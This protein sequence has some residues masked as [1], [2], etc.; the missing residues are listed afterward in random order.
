TESGVVVDVAFLTRG[1]HGLDA[2][3]DLPLEGSRQ[4]AE[5]RSREASAACEV[6]GV[7]NVIFLN[8]SDT[9]LSEEPQLAAS[10]ADVLRSGGYQ[11]VFCPWP[12]DSH[13]DHRATFAHL[14]RAV[15]ESDL[16]PA[17]WLY[18]VWKPLPANTY[19]PIDGTIETKR[20][21]IEQYQSQLPQLNYREGFLGLA[22]Y[23]SLFCPGSS[24]AEAFLVCDRRE[25]LNLT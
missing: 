22:A 6:L 9:R 19:V 5:T 1:E 21:A 3:A 11:R 7:R 23:R 16:N 4:L 8:G 25:M 17:F 12:Q 20:R 13:E 2:G 14:R 18:E 24:Y 10:I 15:Q